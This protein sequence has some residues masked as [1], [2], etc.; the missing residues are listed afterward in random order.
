[1]QGQQRPRFGTG[2]SFTLPST[3]HGKFR[4][5]SG[6]SGGK[7]THPLYREPQG[8]GYGGEGR[9]PGERQVSLSPPSRTPASL[10][11]SPAPPPPPGA[12]RPHA[13]ILHHAWF[14]LSG[15][16]EYISHSTP[17]IEC[18]GRPI[19]LREGGRTARSLSAG[20]KWNPA[21]SAHLAKVTQLGCREVQPPPGGQM[22]TSTASA[23][24]AGLSFAFCVCTE[25][26]ASSFAG[27]LPGSGLLR[28]W[29]RP[30]SPLA[31]N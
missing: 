21:R 28:I 2:M 24:M 7:G 14:F 9:E 22:C 16:C 15:R 27:S 26:K 13:C 10:S 30:A 6:C 23:K 20:R 18:Q 3:E 5:L 1:M 31:L 11:P 25:L 29:R 17:R 8:H 4:G 12:L 19:S